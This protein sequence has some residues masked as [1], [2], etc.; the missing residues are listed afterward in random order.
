[1]V[2]REV[3]GGVLQVRIVRERGHRPVGIAEGEP[4]AVGGA[5][6]VLGEDHARAGL[7]QAKHARQVKLPADRAPAVGQVDIRNGALAHAD[8]NERNDLLDLGKERG[9]ERTRGKPYAGGGYGVGGRRRGVRNLDEVE[10]GLAG[11]GEVLDRKRGVLPG[12]LGGGGRLVRIGDVVGEG[13]PRAG[14]ALPEG[15]Q[16]VAVRPSRGA[17]GG[18]RTCAGPGPPQIAARPWRPVRRTGARRPGAPG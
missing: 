7:A 18:R 10:A 11:V 17:G 14:Q 9:L 5:L 12:D 13:F 4:H 3:D 15:D 8:V 16:G 1:M 2:E 6:D